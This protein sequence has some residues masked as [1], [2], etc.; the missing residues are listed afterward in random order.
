MSW[1]FWTKGSVN[2]LMSDGGDYRTAPAT[3][4]L[5]IT[6]TCLGAQKSSHTSFGAE[7]WGYKSAHTRFRAHTRIHKSAHMNM[8]LRAHTGAHKSAHSSFG[9]QTSSLLFFVVFSWRTKKCRT[10][11]SCGYKALPSRRGPDPL[12]QDWQGQK[13]C[14]PSGSHFPDKQRIQEFIP[15]Q[16]G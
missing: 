3:P 2:Q 11:R 8:S 7:T 13:P 1:R 16:G 14:Q 5:L 4:G 9:S 15:S 12:E 10:T 6:H